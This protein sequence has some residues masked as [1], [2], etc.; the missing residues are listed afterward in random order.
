MTID[1]QITCQIDQQ[2]ARTHAAA[3]EALHHNQVGRF[4]TVIWLSAHLMAAERALH[5]AVRRH[6]PASLPLLDEHQRSDRR[7]HRALRALEQISAGDTFAAVLDEEVVRQQVTRCV[8]AHIATERRILDLLSAAM[9]VGEDCELVERYQHLLA[10]GVTRPHPHAPSSGAL[11]GF[12]FRFD[13]V[14][15][16][17]LDVLDSRTT[18]LPRQRTPHVTPG[19]WGSYVLGSMHD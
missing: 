15:D 16:H 5:P 2:L 14:R 12:V 17:V 10:H 4:D 11:A 3:I 13:R 18:P 6:I 7:L 8:D 1:E 9:T 19:R